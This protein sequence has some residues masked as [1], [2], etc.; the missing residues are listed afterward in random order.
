MWGK[1][2]ESE[3]ELYL[4]FFDTIISFDVCGTIKCENASI[5]ENVAKCEN[6]S[7][8]NVK[9]DAICKKNT[10]NVNKKLGS[11]NVSTFGL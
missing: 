4:T 3:K 8:L 10:L 9:I 11:L 6:I 7:T 5:C 1:N 2:N